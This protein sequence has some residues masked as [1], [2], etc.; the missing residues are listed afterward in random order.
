MTTARDDICPQC[1]HLIIV[2]GSKG[3]LA[4]DC[5]TLRDENF[6]FYLRA[7]IIETRNK[8]DDARSLMHI[9]VKE[10]DIALRKLD[11]VQRLAH[12]YFVERTEAREWAVA[13]C[14]K[15]RRLGE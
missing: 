8:L 3:C 15:L 13:F 5:C 7:E 2:H 1:G 4:C 14:K 6:I 11:S 10:R 9:Y 12:R